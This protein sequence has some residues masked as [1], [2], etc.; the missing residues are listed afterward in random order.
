MEYRIPVIKQRFF[1]WERAPIEEFSILKFGVDFA[2]FGDIGRTWFNGEN[3]L[4]IDY[5][6]GYG[7]ELNFILP[8]DL[9]F[10]VGYALNNAGGKQIFVDFRAGFE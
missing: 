8:Y 1:K 3:V 10:G 9:L 4:K 5:L 6:K 2:I 7:V